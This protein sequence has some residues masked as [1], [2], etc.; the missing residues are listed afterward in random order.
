[1]TPEIETALREAAT[2]ARIVDADLV[3]L[4][5]FAEIVGRM[6]SESDATRAVAEM[7]QARPKLFL[8]DDYA[9][10]SPEEF[11]TAETRFREKL[12]R[13]SRPD[14]ARNDAFKKLDAALLSPGESH[15]LR[16]F[17]GGTR[18]GYDL[19]VLRQALRRQ[20]GP[21]AA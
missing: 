12:A 9:L 14:T 1:M 2:A 17:L 13:R 18:N 19:S 15:A 4:A 7:R 11:D 20:N 21:D 5:V 3:T 10:M 16:R 6:A 8:H